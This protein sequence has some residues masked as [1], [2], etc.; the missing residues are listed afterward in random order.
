MKNRLTS[1]KVLALLE[2]TKE[3]IMY[4]DASRVSLGCALMH[5]GKVISYS[6]RQLK[7]HLRNYPTH[8][9]ELAFTVFPLKIRRH[10]LYGVRGDVYTDHKS[11]HYVITQKEFNLRQ[12]RWLELLKD[13]DMS[14]IYNPSKT[15][16]MADALSRMTICS[17]SHVKKAKKDLLNDVHRLARLGVR[18]EDTPNGCLILWSIITSSNVLLLRLS[19]SNIFDQPLIVFKE[20]FLGKRNKSFFLRR[21]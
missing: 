5:H 16:V 10:Y 13:Y 12:R 6:P 15:N 14:V 19:L 9:L 21:C 11:L 8:D 3:F 17:V 18:L 7:V 1:A 20:S 4:C 2:G